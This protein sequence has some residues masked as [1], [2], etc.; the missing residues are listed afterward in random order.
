MF[1]IHTI[2][3]HKRSEADLWRRIQFAADGP[4]IALRVSI[5][6]I[7]WNYEEIFENPHAD[8]EIG[9]P[10]NSEQNSEQLR[11]FL[12]QKFAAERP[13][14]SSGESKFYSIATM[15]DVGGSRRIKWVYGT[16]GHRSGPEIDLLATPSITVTLKL[17]TRGT[18]P[19]IIFMPLILGDIYVIKSRFFRAEILARCCVFLQS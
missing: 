8:F 13:W 2:R 5:N 7:L 10:S 11:A 4:E 17:T 1:W 19:S 18:N 12:E 6:H 3:V 15:I 16:H 14:G 9:T